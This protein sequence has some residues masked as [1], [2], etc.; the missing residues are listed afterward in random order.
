MKY[1]AISLFSG[2]SGLDL[3]IERAGF[4]IGVCVDNDKY[5]CE[6]IRNN[7]RVPI[8]EKDINDVKGKELLKI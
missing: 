2:A 7:T 1:R 4:G 6:T 8:V 5:C 3:G